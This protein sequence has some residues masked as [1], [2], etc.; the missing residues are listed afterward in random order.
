MP[1]PSPELLLPTPDPVRITPDDPELHRLIQAERVRMMLAPTVPVALVSALCCVILA[2]VLA[3][4][5]GEHAALAW[6][7]LGVLTSAAR[8]VHLRLYARAHNKA[9]DRW[10]TSLTVV[11]TLHGMVWGMAGLLMPVQ[12]LVTSVTVVATLLGASAIA[13]FTM[14]AH[15]RT[16][17]LINVPML[18]PG[19][20]M[21]LTRQDRYGVYGGVGMMVI[22][23]MMLY[24][25][26]RAELR[27]VELLWLRFTTDHIANERAEALELAQRHSAVKDQF[28][29]TMSHEMRT[30][31]HGI[32]GLAQL[33][34]TRLPDRPGVL[35]EARHQL[36]LIE[37]TGEHLL[38]IINDVLDFSR[39]EA[40]KLQIEQAPFELGAVMQ[41]VLNLLNVTATE[42]GLKMRKDMRVPLPCWVM[43]DAARTRQV[44]HN[45][46]GNAIKFT[47]QGEVR[48]RARRQAA[49][50]GASEG[51]MVITVED[52][53]QGIPADQL[54]FVFDAFHQVDGSF[55]RKHKGTGLGLTISRE[56]THAMGGDITCQSTLGQGTTF[57][58]TLP[59]PGTAVR[60]VDVALPLDEANADHADT[61][62]TPLE[63][64]KCHALLAEDNA[65]NALVAEATL[66]N[67]GVTVTRVEN[68]AQALE[69][70]QRP[71]RPFDLVLMDCQMPVLN[72]IETVRRLRLWET[73][74]SQPYMTVIALTANAAPGDRARC[75]GAGMDDHLAKPFKQRELRAML[76]R[77]LARAKDASP[78][79]IGQ[80]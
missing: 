37:R 26:R 15:L 21:L 42:K 48:V 51:A 59:L 79:A 60:T 2:Y 76:R 57:T 23:A 30:P 14:Q 45:L 74:N 46:V 73:E 69:A 7:I 34:R 4:Q 13:T 75:I 64:L 35:S 24:E 17:V 20:L 72:G 28:L 54:A 6:A 9:A 77:H 47:D 29:A 31:L 19:A 65:V 68:G 50:P 18:L 55:G 62:P 36:E 43:G 11:C 40:G 71:D 5:V 80:A 58:L 12:D 10:I 1:P 3:P 52:T 67:L 27:I 53:G 44:L 16:N 41:D 25:S 32:L 33:V 78:T 63:S 66:A 8:L 38:D 56:I 70:L 22:L 61:A 39:I 49:S